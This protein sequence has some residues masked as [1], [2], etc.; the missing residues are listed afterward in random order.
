VLPAG[1]IDR[2]SKF[3]ANSN[4]TARD[5]CPW[6]GTRV[7]PLKQKKDGFIGYS[8]R[9]SLIAHNLESFCEVSIDSFDE[10]WIVIRTR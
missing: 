10:H 7:P 9:V 4:E 5:V 1:V 6:H 8:Y 3:A 2:K